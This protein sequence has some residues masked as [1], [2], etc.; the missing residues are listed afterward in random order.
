MAPSFGVNAKFEVRAD[1][2]NFLNKLNINPN[3]ID[4][5]LGSLNPD[6][7]LHVKWCPESRLRRGRQRMG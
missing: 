6:G 2:Y 4:V 1:V 7:T 3:S 5:F